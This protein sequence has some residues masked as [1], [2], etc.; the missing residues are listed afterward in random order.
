MPPLPIVSGKQAVRAFLKAGWLQSRRESSHVVMVKP[1]STANLS[2]PDHR[3]LDR[4]LLRKQ[5][6]L[7]G[8]SGD[9]FLELLD[10]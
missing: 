3:E 6:R 2:I 5:I 8:L 10:K 9:E 7:A 1:G 4:G